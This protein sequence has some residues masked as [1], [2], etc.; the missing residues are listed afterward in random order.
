M[1]KKL[2]VLAF[3]L[4]AIFYFLVRVGVTQPP[5][6]FMGDN[7]L[8][9]DK[10]DIEV[11]EIV[12]VQVQSADSGLPPYSFN[13]IPMRGDF[14]GNN[15]QETASNQPD[16]TSPFEL[17]STAQEMATGTL[18]LRAVHPGNMLLIVSSSTD[19]TPIPHTWNPPSSNLLSLTV[20][21]PLMETTITTTLNL[22]EKISDLAWSADG[23]KLGAMGEQTAYVW[24]IDGDTAQNRLDLLNTPNEDFGRIVLSPEGDVLYRSI[25]RTSD[26]SPAGGQVQHWDMTAGIRLTLWNTEDSASSGK[27]LQLAINPEGNIVGHLLWLGDA[28]CPRQDTYF[29]QWDR[30]TGD[31]LPTIQLPLPYINEFAYGGSYLALHLVRSLCGPVSADERLIAIYENG[32]EIKTLPSPGHDG[33]HQIEFSRDGHYLAGSSYDYNQDYGV[34]NYVHV[35]RD[36]E[37]AFVFAA[38][39]LIGQI[40]IS[41]NSRY[42]IIPT[43][44]QKYENSQMITYGLR[45][46]VIELATGKEIGRIETDND[47]LDDFAI[48]PDGQLLAFAT[49]QQIVILRLST[50]L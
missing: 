17:I 7:Y 27:S 50:G 48:S 31:Q 34:T 40:A 11:G 4:G 1:V 19:R 10:I 23:Q 18:Q 30:A 14:D 2:A 46:H 47:D 43:V 29:Y 9:A 8:T 24:K 16:A 32:I 21:P 44:N 38:R 12:T 49:D 28:G 5:L 26:D 6:G 39:D 36:F 25:Y 42:L 35:W 41:A 20:L 33:L 45:F 37:P 15:D 3:A 22:P 13:F